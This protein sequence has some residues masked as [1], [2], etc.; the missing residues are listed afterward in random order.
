[1]NEKETKERIKRGAKAKQLLNDPMIQEFLEELRNDL[2]HNIRT[3]HF[4]D[5]DEREELY[6]MLR[7]ADR[8]EQMFILHINTG[9]LAQSR[10]DQMK[11]K[12]TDISRKLKSLP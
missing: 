1:M 3:S 6:K 12:V 10:F 4:K 7:I 9:K 2:F 11:E 8:F 5:V